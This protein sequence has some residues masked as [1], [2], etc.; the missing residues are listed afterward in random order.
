[1]NLRFQSGTRAV[2]L[3]ISDRCAAGT[4]TDRSGPAVVSLLRQAGIDDLAA[5]TLPDELDLIAHSLRH[6][7]AEADLII[8]TGGTGLAPRDVTP[9][10]TLMVCD[11]TVEGL[12]EVMRAEGLKH[13]PT[14]V[15]SRAVCGT[16]GTTLII[17]LP[18]SLNGAQTSLAVILPVL[19]HAVDLLN[20]RTAHPNP[21]GEQSPGAP[22]QS[23]SSIDV[24]GNKS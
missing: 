17:N 14:A 18:G 1:V 10:A 20:G 5:E 22:S 6:H 8:T 15:L 19:P 4:Q 16:I 3:T 24:G 2:V 23:A 11:R 7:A 21:P 9:E 12:S 13:T